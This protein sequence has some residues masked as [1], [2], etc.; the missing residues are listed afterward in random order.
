MTIEAAAPRFRATSTDTI[1]LLIFGRFVPAT[2]FAMLG[3]LQ[4]QR[5]ASNV[6]GLSRPVDALSVISGPLPAAL[7]LLFCAIPVFIYIGRPA[8][9]ARDGRW[10][11]RAAGL[12]GTVMLLVVGA[13]P[14]GARLY[15]PPPWLGGVSTA[16]S[17]V[18]FA[19][20]VYGLLYLRRSL[21]IIPEVRRLV[22]GG[23][24]RVVRHPLY[25]A[26][27]LAAS[28]FVM[29]NPGALAVAMLAPFVATQLLRSRFEES[30]LT[31]AYP[32]Y[33]D[34]ARHTRRL[35]PFLW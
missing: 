7:Y 31:V 32:E 24:Y 15:S 25:A 22:T 3:Y 27:I 14:Q 35:V 12:T 30:L 16:L 17:V 21:S 26:E 9:R 2:F 29:V 4:F 23:P 6:R 33:R 13:L 20:A 1:R 10:L 5:L 34:Y 11:P 8:P 18:A 28:A 19:L